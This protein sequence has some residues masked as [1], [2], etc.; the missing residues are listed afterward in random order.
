MALKERQVVLLR[1][2]LR[3]SDPWELLGSD[4]SRPALPSFFAS[5]RPDLARA[6]NRA[7]AS[8]PLATSRPAQLLLQRERLL[9]GD[10]R[11]QSVGERRDLGGHLSVA[12]LRRRRA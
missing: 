7:A 10:P 1:E 12:S 3:F 4:E 6:W 9:V 5:F 11:E 2:A 8:R